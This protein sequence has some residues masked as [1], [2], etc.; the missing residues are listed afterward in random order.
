MTNINYLNSLLQ[1][2]EAYGVKV[3]F[4][5]SN[6]VE[7]FKKEN[8]EAVLWVNENNMHFTSH[9][10]YTYYINTYLKHVYSLPFVVAKIEGRENIERLKEVILNNKDYSDRIVGIINEL[11]KTK[12]LTLR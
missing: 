10:E 3:Y 12:K 11:D 9:D 7:E 4:S 8:P 6:F 5:V 2:N 1:R